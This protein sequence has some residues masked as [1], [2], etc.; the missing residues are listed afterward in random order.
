MTT[1]KQTTHN[2][3]KL[4]EGLRHGDLHH[5]IDS[6]V[7]I[8]RYKSKMGDDDAVV[9]LGFKVMNKEVAED[10]VSFIESGYNLSL[11]HI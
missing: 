7:S 8:D 4:F 5:T 11:I 2:K 1:Q 3:R 6:N 9:V 10:L